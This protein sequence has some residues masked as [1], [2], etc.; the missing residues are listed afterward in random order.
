MSIVNQVVKKIMQQVRLPMPP[1]Y[2]DENGY[3]QRGERVG[4][5]LPPDV[6]YDIERMR[7]H[8]EEVLS[9]ESDVLGEYFP[10][11]SPGLL[12]L[13]SDRLG[14][15]FW[16]LALE[17]YHKGY[18][19]EYQDFERMAHMVVMKTY[20]HEQFHHFCDVNRHLF[21]TRFD[22]FTEEALA[23]AW[24]YH[25]L[26]E[27]RRSWQTKEARLA[28]PFYYELMR[29]MYRYTSPGYRDWVHYQTEAD[30]RYGLVNYLGPQKA[31][32][33]ESSGINVANVLLRILD[34]V[35]DKGVIEE[36]G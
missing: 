30:F 6:I 31:W 36:I 35:K 4:I 13:Y 18:Y 11:Q 16:H 9:Q 10:M 17:I 2:Y 33:L 3:Q 15:F 7:P 32:F 20:F 23:V 29:G 21:A 5:V 19:M 22:R 24:S 14:S 28:S 12:I 27:L 8:P 1:R 25:Q 26:Q 34:E